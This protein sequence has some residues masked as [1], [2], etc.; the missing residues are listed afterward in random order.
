MASPLLTVAQAAELLAVSKPTIYRLV[1][2]HGL[3]VVRITSDMR[4]RPEDIDAWL[5][6]R[7]VGA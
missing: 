2:N 3:P 1:R 4:F 6:S 7:K 5:E